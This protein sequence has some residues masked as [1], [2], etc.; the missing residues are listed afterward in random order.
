MLRNINFSLALLMGLM[1][2]K[3]PLK[4]NFAGKAVHRTV[5]TD[6]KVDL[7]AANFQMRTFYCEII[8]E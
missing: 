3:D 8:V 7:S 5:M 4:P 6:G 2:P 1:V